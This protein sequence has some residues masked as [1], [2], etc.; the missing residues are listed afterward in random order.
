MSHLFSQ[1]AGLLWGVEDL[2]VEDRKVEGQAQTDGVGGRHLLVGQTRG[3]L[4]CL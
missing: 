2:E 4:V 1:T 3:V